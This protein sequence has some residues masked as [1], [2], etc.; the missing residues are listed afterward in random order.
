MILDEIVEIKRRQLEKEKRN[1]SFDGFEQE[2]YKL[3]NFRGALMGE[4]ISIIGEIKRASPSKGMI[5]ENF[6]LECIAGI[7]ENLAID[8]VSVLTERHFFRGEDEYLARVRRINIKPL[9]RKD[10][11]ID[12]YQ[13]FQAR[14]IGADAVLLIESLLGDRLK[15]FYNIASSLGLTSLVEVHNEDELKRVLEVGCEIIGINNR[16]LRDFTEDI[17]TTE[18]LM[19]HI[20]K[21]KITVSES[22]IK[23]LS[24]IKFLKELGI[25][26]VLIGE[27][28]MR[29]LDN[30]D[31]LK[32]FVDAIKTL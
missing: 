31:K 15:S 2:P 8:A 3:R 28:L 18:R 11:I 20:P 17:R 4:G 25:N 9:L 6:N 7:Y 10:F 27:T 14:A 21:G 13:L 26:A 23:T 16:D 1:I 22:S 30:V 29:G 12:E 32:D 19:K 5:R 24:D